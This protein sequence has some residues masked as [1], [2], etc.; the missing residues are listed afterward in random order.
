MSEKNRLQAHYHGQADWLQWGPYLSEREWGTL[1]EFYG[2][3]DNFWQG[4]GYQQARH[5]AYRWGEDGIAG[6]CDDQ[7]FLCLSLSL[8]NY[9]DS[10]LKERLFGLTNPEGNHGEDLKE[11]FFYLYN[12]PTH[13][14]SKFSYKYPVSAFPYQQLIE[15]NRQRSQHESEYELFDTGIFAAGYFDVVVTYAKAAP[16]DI[17]CQISVTNHSSEVKKILLAPQIWFRN[18]WSWGYPNGPEGKVFQKPQL[19]SPVNLQTDDYWIIKADHC[20]LGRYYLYLPPA[21]EVVMTENQTETNRSRGQ[22]QHPWFSKQAVADYLTGHS[23]KINHFLTGTKATAAYHWQLKP[24][25]T[26]QLNLRLTRL[27]T[28]HPWSKLTSTIQQRRQ[29]AVEFFHQLQSP[30][31]PTELQNLQQQAWTNLLTSKQVYYF[32]VQQWRQGDPSQPFS[33]E[34]VALRPMSGWQHL[35]N[36]QV[37][38]MPDKW[39]YPWYANWDLALQSWSMAQLDLQL[40][41]QQLLLL[42]KTDYMHPNGQLP[43]YEVDWNAVNPPLLAWAGLQ[44][45]EWEKNQTNQPDLSFLQQLF[46]KLIFNFSWWVNRKDRDGKNIFEGGFLGLDNIGVLDRNLPGIQGRLSQA[47]STSWMAMYALNMVKIALHLAVKQPVYQDMA[48][49]FLDHFLRIAQTMSHTDQHG[50]SLFDDQDQFYY[51]VLHLNDRSIAMKVRSLVGLVP[52]LAVEILEPE[53]INQLPGFEQK[54]HQLLNNFPQLAESGNVASCELPGIGKRRLLSLVN[55]KRLQAILARML[56]P[57]EFLSPFGIRSLSRYHLHHPFE[58]ELHGQHYQIDYQPGESHSR[59]FGGNSNWRGPIWMPV[60]YLIIQ[61]LRKHH[62]YY[63]NQVTFSFPHPSD[64]KLTL[65]QIAEQLSFRLI[66][67][68]VKNTDGSRPWQGPYAH[69]FSKLNWQDQLFYE[70]FH[71]ETGQG[72]GACHQAW[73]SLIANLIAETDPAHLLEWYQSLALGVEEAASEAED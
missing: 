62:L 8:W 19:E 58:F 40:A 63:G 14:Y 59:M 52:L 67:L 15:V 39:E 49:K 21:H 33:A 54:M 69:W 11:Y 22:H 28:T 46:H 64:N 70:Y 13:S 20:Q 34:E 71:A 36:H 32:D 29:E 45:F 3:G 6:W 31:L 53:L 73:T 66:S 16:D 12:T 1:R 61:A 27:I 18:T 56:D 51:D 35:K 43:A 4:L 48:I 25:Q 60:N 5:T 41:K 7:Q 68:F 17:I 44:I 9:Q 37:I 10:H 26:K 57:E 38:M 30:L 55:H 23:T 72:L 42:T 65:H 24:Q 47:D 50:L 2:M